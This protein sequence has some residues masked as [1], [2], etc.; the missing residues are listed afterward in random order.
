M[1]Q[2]EKKMTQNKKLTNHKLNNDMFYLILN[3]T[4]LIRPFCFVTMIKCV[5]CKSLADSI[6]PNTLCFVVQLLS[7]KLFECLVTF[8]HFA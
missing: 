5:Q 6:G 4:L 8:G 2:N 7:I 3:V 1:T